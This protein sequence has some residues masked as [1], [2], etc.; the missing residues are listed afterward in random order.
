MPVCNEDGQK[1]KFMIAKFDGREN[2]HFSVYLITCTHAHQ[3]VCD[4]IRFAS[5]CEPLPKMT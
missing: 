2:P 5:R 4:P 3:M 1:Y